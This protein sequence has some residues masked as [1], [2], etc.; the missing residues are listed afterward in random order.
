M[1][2]PLRWV[3][4][5][6]H[7]HHPLGARCRSLVH[8]RFFS[9]NL[10]PRRN[11]RR[12][13]RQDQRCRAPRLVIVAAILGLVHSFERRSRRRPPGPDPPLT[14]LPLQVVQDVLGIGQAGRAV[15]QGLSSRGHGERTPQACATRQQCCELGA[16]TMPLL[17]QK[18]NAPALGAFEG[19]PPRIPAAQNLRRC[20]H[21]RPRNRLKAPWPVDTWPSRRLPFWHDEPLPVAQAFYR[22]PGLRLTAGQRPAWAARKLTTPRWP[23]KCPCRRARSAGSLPSLRAT[24]GTELTSSPTLPVTCCS[25]RV[26]STRTSVGTNVFR[27]QYRGRARADLPA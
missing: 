15:H 17:A 12:A 16:R 5:V 3:A 21:Q 8:R 10:L 25:K 11:E 13:S 6:E 26:T 14:A 24:L 18:L 1:V 4:V 19:W 20:P 27:P 22:R 2:C 23:P 7:H 9:P